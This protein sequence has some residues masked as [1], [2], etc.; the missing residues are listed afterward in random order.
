MALVA[1]V[2]GTAT[3]HAETFGVTKHRT[4]LEVP[5]EH[6]VGYTDHADDGR[7]I[8]AASGAL[9]AVQARASGTAGRVVLGAAALGA[10]LLVQH[11]AGLDPDGAML[12]ADT[13]TLASIGETVDKIQADQ[14]A[15]IERQKEVNAETEKGL[16][17][18][19]EARE[20]MS[21]R[22]DDLMETVEGVTKALNEVAQDADRPGTGGTRLSAQDKKERQA[23]NRYA[24]NGEASRAFTPEDHETLTNALAEAREMSTDS[25]R[26]G[27]VF[28]PSQMSD[29][30]VERTYEYSPVRQDATVETIT[31]GD[32]LDIPV[33]DLADDYT[34]GWVGEREERG[35]T[36]T[37]A[38]GLVSIDVH[39]QFAQPS[40]TNKMLEDAGID[41]EARLTRG[42]SRRFGLGEG[43]G[44][45]TG[46]GV[47]KPHG[48]LAE[49]AIKQ[50]LKI[51]AIFNSGEAVKLSDW[52][53]LAKVMTAL[54]TEYQAM[55]KW[56]W[57]R[58]VSYIAW[59]MVDGEERPLLNFDLVAEGGPMQFLG[60][61]VVHV[62]AMPAYDL[63]TETFTT[64]DVP[65][66]FADMGELY[67]IVDRRGIVTL[68]DNLTRKGRTKFYTPRRVGGAPVQY[69]AARLIRIGA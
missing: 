35:E 7:G 26:D 33:E 31:T 45:V 60:K 20:E 5:V 4:F 32:R 13:V 65:V 27:G 12:L 55:A 8:P 61:P 21:K 3:A 54:P 49:R 68:R 40:L 53:V 37:E 46:N 42:I 19:A 44:F 38:F 41:I 16:R 1:L 25:L 14:Q 62:D 17:G 2:G 47:K 28:V 30:I 18:E 39:E 43:I 9:S 23:F 24:R 67:T 69:D 6:Y 29:R 66:M 63:T 36:D 56:Y 58:S 48:Y 57:N 22:F 34:S 64:G 50:F 59:T 11:A 52:K 15:A 10:V 51:Q